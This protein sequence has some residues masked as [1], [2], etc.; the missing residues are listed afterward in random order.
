[1]AEVSRDDITLVLGWDDLGA[2]A[3]LRRNQAG[4]TTIKAMAEEATAENPLTLNAFL[5]AFLCPA[6][7]FDL[8]LRE[9]LQAITSDIQSITERMKEI[10]AFERDAASLNDGLR[11]TYLAARNVVARRSARDERRTLATLLFSGPSTARQ[12]AE[13]L[14]IAEG[15]AVRTLRTL[16]SVLKQQPG[17]QVVLRSDPD[18]LAVVL[19]L[20]RSTLGID[21]I[22]VL[23]RRLAG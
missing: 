1:M 8:F 6:K 3:G 21:P 14:G 20:L 11:M 7:N 22:R 12:I 10:E 18:T 15:L 17:G 9:N 23:E 2:S 5:Y 4:F 13:D 19:H 16:A